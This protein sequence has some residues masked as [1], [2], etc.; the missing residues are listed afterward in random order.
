MGNILSQLDQLLEQH[1]SRPSWDTYFL[2]CAKMIASRSPCSRLHVGCIL[3]DGVDNLHRIIASGYNGF[4]PGIP[5]FS[6][7]RDCHELATVHAEQNA[8]ADAAR[9]GVR[10]CGAEVYITHYPCIHCSKLLLAA[11][12]ISLKYGVDYNNDPIV[13]ELF[14]ACAIPI[15]RIA[16]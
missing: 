8:I 5:H 3:V 16:P 9:R 1:N 12:I 11:G 15:S 13:E 7:V 10:V 4:L 6:R 2:M 14:S